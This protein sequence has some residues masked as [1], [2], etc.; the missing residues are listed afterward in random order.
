MTQ[1]PPRKRIHLDDNAIDND[2]EATESQPQS[3]REP[4]AS[5]DSG[6]SSQQQQQPTNRSTP[7]PSSL[8]SSTQPTQS[9]DNRHVSF[10]PG[11]NQEPD[12]P[13]ERKPRLVITKMV[14]NNFKSY[15][16]RQV[17]GPFQKVRS[18]SFFLGKEMLIY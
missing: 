15:A 18:Y 1:Q 12:E 6:D 7:R 13:T 3:Q 5:T 9:T 11:T 16:G 2:I 8:R 10:A 4:S 14:L 17:I